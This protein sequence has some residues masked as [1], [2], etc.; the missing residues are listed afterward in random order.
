[1][2]HV[3]SFSFAVCLLLL[4][5]CATQS[6]MATGPVNV[7]ITS[8]TAT[9]QLL[10]DVRNAT[11]AAIEKQAPHARPV[12][13]TATLY[14]V[15]EGEA[16]F[17]HGTAYAGGSG[18]SRGSYSAGVTA[19]GMSVPST[20]SDP[21][22]EGSI[23][24]VGGYDTSA[25]SLPSGPTRGPITWMRV[26]YTIKDANGRVLESKQQWQPTDR[27]RQG[28]ELIFPVRFDSARVADT[29]AFLASRVAALSQ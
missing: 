16:D 13:V 22:T 11:L 18:M 8:E 6:R 19:A 29:A 25:S 17:S 9:K 20:G 21:R 12:T 3:V 7:T 23:P 14:V 2:K 5:A 15:Y 1:M 26:S 28:L 24:T 27:P 10:N 4:S